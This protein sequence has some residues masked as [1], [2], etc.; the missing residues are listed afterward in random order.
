MLC[1]KTKRNGWE[2]NIAGASRERQKDRRWLDRP[3]GRLEPGTEGRYGKGKGLLVLYLVTVTLVL[4]LALK[5]SSSSSSASGGMLLNELLLFPSC[6]SR[7]RAGRPRF[8]IKWWD[9]SKPIK[10]DTCR[11]REKRSKVY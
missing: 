10:E 3:T 1:D 9:G 6:I 2:M 8:I 5:S 11:E 4:P 7:D